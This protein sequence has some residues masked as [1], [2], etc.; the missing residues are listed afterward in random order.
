VRF[1]GFGAALAIVVAGAHPAPAETAACA[2]V[3]GGGGKSHRYDA[4]LAPG[5]SARFDGVPASDFV[6][7]TSGPCVFVVYND[8][9]FA[10]RSVRLGS[11]LDDRIRA[12]LDG[13]VRR[14]KGGGETWRVRSVRME[15]VETACRLRLG[16]G[17]VRMT[18]FA[19]VHPE[20]PAMDRVG[21]L[22]GEGCTADIWNGT[23]FGAHDPDNRF[24]SLHASG[25]RSEAYDP[26]FGV[27]SLRIMAGAARCPA[28]AR[29]QG[30]CLPQILLDRGLRTE[31]APRDRD[32]DGLDDEMENQLAAAFRPI[33]VNHS[34]ED[35]TRTGIYR[36]AGGDSV[37]EP[38]T[39]FQVDREGKDEIVI[40]FMKLWRRDVYD[41]VLCGGHEGDSQPHRLYLRTAPAGDARRGR[42]WFVHRV[43]GGIEQD[44]DWAAGDRSLRG[45]RF[46]GEAGANGTATHLVIYF[47]KG[48]HHEYGDGGWSGQTDRGCVNIKAHTNGRGQ[49]HQPPLPRRAAILR[50]PAGHGDR[51]DFTNVGTVAHPFFDDLGPY[52][53]PGQRV[54][55]GKLFYSKKAQPVCRI[56]GCCES[57]RC[58]E[59]E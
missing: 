24:K 31:S 33:Y 57:I 7:S 36:S 34:S 49:L 48:K 44:L 45:P 4:R 5:Q 9:G 50:S 54:W 8:A 30:R 15:R 17:G 1:V 47:S 32:R 41:Q 37:S 26:G 2:I 46:E 56:F 19:G 22:V 29:D 52:G 21:E 51:F 23:D 14:D 11:E 53:F 55:S 42:F 12:G 58:Q 6:R 16:G 38:A 39:L 20:V 10:G 25:P 13:I 27:R 43:R 59:T 3:V 18:Y 40:R 35:G 28:F